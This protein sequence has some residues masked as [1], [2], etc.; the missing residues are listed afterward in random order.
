M[1][2]QMREGSGLGQGGGGGAA[3]WALLCSAG[4][5]W[6]CWVWVRERSGRL[7]CCQGLGLSARQAG[8]GLGD[9]SGMWLA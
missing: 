1:W 4:G 7:G 2:G 9:R 3:P 5:A 6:V 8:G